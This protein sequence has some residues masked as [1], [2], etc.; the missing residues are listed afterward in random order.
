MDEI[1][2]WSTFG[3][4]VVGIIG[5]TFA[6]IAVTNDRKRIKKQEDEKIKEI[7]KVYHKDYGPHVSII[8]GHAWGFP[9]QLVNVT[10][11]NYIIRLFILSNGGVSRPIPGGNFFSGSTIEVDTKNVE[12]NDLLVIHA[13]PT[14]DWKCLCSTTTYNENLRDYHH[15]GN[16][17][18]FKHIANEI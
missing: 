7:Q 9:I 4:L 11:N 5:G 8:P 1:E 2:A 17:M 14:S 13:D 6:F 18:L 15:W 3:A 12:T 16:T 10:E